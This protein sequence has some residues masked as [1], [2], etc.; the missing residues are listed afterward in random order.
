[1]LLLYGM[2]NSIQ[3]GSVEDKSTT[4]LI[5]VFND[6]SINV[7]PDL[8]RVEISSHDTLFWRYQTGKPSTFLATIEALYYTVLSAHRCVC[9]RWSRFRGTGENMDGGVGLQEDENNINIS[10][11]AVTCSI[12]SSPSAVLGQGPKLIRFYPDKLD[13]HSWIL[14][15]CRFKNSCADFS[16]L[17]S[18]P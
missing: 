18:S 5:C 10:V 6:W 9:L 11:I 3:F 7:Q 4:I 14:K 2:Y 17:D 12:C 1:M 15:L 13:R 8:P 16:P